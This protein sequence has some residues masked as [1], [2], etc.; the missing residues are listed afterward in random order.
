MANPP[1][2]SKRIAKGPSAY[3][4]RKSGFLELT[5]CLAKNVTPTDH[6][7]MPKEARSSHRLIPIPGWRSLNNRNKRG[8][9]LKL[10]KEGGANF[11]L[12]SSSDFSNNSVAI[13]GFAAPLVAF[14]TCPNIYLKTD[15]LP[16]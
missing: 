9:S 8:D 15:L 1:N 16:E 11:Y 2:I 7:A 14:I 5:N 10:D 3:I 13:S 6:V 4:L 12:N